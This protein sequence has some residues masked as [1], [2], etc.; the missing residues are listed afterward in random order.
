MFDQRG[1]LDAVQQQVH[2]S[3]A[4]HG[5]IELYAV[6]HPLVEVLAEGRVVE[7]GFVVLT[8]VLAGVDQEA[9]RAEGGVADGVLRGR[10]AHPHHQLDDV[11]GRAKLPV[12]ARRGHLAEQVLV[13]VALGV[14]PVHL[15]LRQQVDRL[16]QQAG[17][18]DDEVGSA[19]VA[20]KHTVVVA[21]QGLDEGKHPVAHPLEHGFG[22][23]QVLEHRP[24]Q[25]ALLVGED[26]V[27]NGLPG[28]VGLP[29]FGGLELVRAV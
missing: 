15:D 27:L 11:A 24:P 13:E 9:R 20:G 17:R 16:G 26:G 25:L 8:Q 2:G 12:F 21:A 3:D 6:E 22:V 29:L 4:D 1:V 28:G 19:H 18:G 10:S 5:V 7:L 14:A 23:A